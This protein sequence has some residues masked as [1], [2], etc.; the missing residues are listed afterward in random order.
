MASNSSPDYKALYLQEREVLRQVRE[1]RRQ[2][3]EAHKQIEARRKEVEE[4]LKRS[5]F[6]ELVRHCH[7]LLSRPL[8]VGTLSCS[9]TGTI[10]L[11]KGKYCPTRL[12]QW[13]DCVAQQQDI[14][15]SVRRYLQPEENPPRIFA[16]RY[17][18]EGH[19]EIVPQLIRSERDLRIYEGMAV[20]P[21]VCKVMLELCEIA[22][23]REEFGLGDE[24]LFSRDPNV[25]GGDEMVETDMIP[26]SSPDQFFIHRVDGR[27]TTTLLTTVEYVP[28]NKLSLEDLRVG[29]GDM[30]LWEKMVQGNKVLNNEADRSVYKAQRL[31]CSAIVHEYHVMI[32]EGLE[33][34]YLSTGIALVLLWVPREKPSTLYYHLC[35]PN[36]EVDDRDGDIPQPNTYIARVLCLCLMSFRSRQR[37]QEWRNVCSDLHTWEMNF[38]HTHANATTEE[39]PQ[40]T[41]PNSTDYVSL[42]SDPTGSEYQAS[43]SSIKSPTTPARRVPT[44]SQGNCEPL[45]LKDRM[46]SADPFGYES[47][48]A[49]RAQDPAAAARKRGYCQVEHSPPRRLSPRNEIDRHNDLSQRRSAQ[50]RTQRCLLGLQNGGPLDDFCPNVD[51]HRQGGNGTQHSISAVE[52]ISLLKQQMD[53]DIDRC[54]PFGSRG[55]Y[56]APFK[57][58]CS[59]HGYTV[60]GKGTTAV[61]WAKA[62]SQEADI[63][64][65]LRKAQGSA[66]PVFLGKIDLAKIYFRYSAEIRHMLV[67]GWAGESTA[68][69]EQTSDLRREIKR[70]NKEIRSLGVRHLDLRPD[71]ILWNAELGRALII[72]FHRSELNRRRPADKSRPLKRSRHKAEIS[73]S[74]RVRVI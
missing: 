21:H 16:S 66:V 39:L 22:A 26:H 40:N 31:V 63:Y 3:S 47:N 38:D 27:G 50:F 32:Q 34:S 24:V 4:Q 19:P 14:Y 67:M 20:D 73:E 35:V 37:D 45:D 53:E 54:I 2:E 42:E 60:V 17:Q 23:A 13:V 1:V 71:N 74:K 5:T 8:R 28:P 43:S 7:D 52:L 51:L 61:I 55:S 36:Q 33:Y 65:I 64:H 69:L 11:P 68:T 25:L 18:L 12:E 29:L 72:D 62:V 15:D 59:I 41:P 44:R 6:V 58:T 46:G 70:S 30:D 56:G 10:P 48:P 9:T 49:A 57:L